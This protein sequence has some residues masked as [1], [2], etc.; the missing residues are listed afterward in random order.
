MTDAPI[1]AI[2]DLGGA[3]R[4][5]LPTH[6]VAQSLQRLLGDLA[7]TAETPRVP[8]GDQIVDLLRTG[9]DQVTGIVGGKAF[10]RRQQQGLPR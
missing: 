7:R 8:F 1:P 6:S 5:S 2:H 10:Q 4:G 9:L 3:I